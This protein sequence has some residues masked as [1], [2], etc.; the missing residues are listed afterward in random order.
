MTWELYALGA[1]ALLFG[2]AW[3]SAAEMSYSSANRLRISAAEEDG[4]RGAK[5]ARKLLDRFT[6]T[7]AAI[8]IGNNLCNIGSDSL[9]TVLAMTLLGSRYNAGVSVG[10]TAAVTLFVILFCET[11]PKLSAKKNA[12]RWTLSMSAPLR[13]VTAILMPAVWVVRILA[14]WISAPFPKDEQSEEPEEAAAE[15]QSIIETVEDEG[16]IDEDRGEMLLSALDF[17]QIPVMDVMTARVDVQAL[18]TG[19][20]WRETLLRE[21]WEPFSRIPVYEGSIDDIIGILPVN[22]FFRAL[23]ED[24]QTDVRSCLMEPLYVYKTVKLP[25]VLDQFRR[26]QQHLAVV[27]DEYGGTLGIVTLEDVLEQIVGDIWDESDE[28]E[29]KILPRPDGSLEVD[30]SVPLSDFAE[31]LGMEE[32]IQSEDSATAGGWVLERFGTFPQEG[33]GFRFEGAGFTVLKM[34][35]DGRRVEKILVVPPDR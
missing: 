13:L 35:E 19:E 34:D 20:D 15:L 3:C 21:D 11:V 27:T 6:D 9:I 14:K 12:N 24:P 30:G 32:T 29:E 5:R 18:D 17:S 7:L 33:D 23:L 16:V 2:S 28:V 1:A 31:R 4:V 8:L 26:H 22:R 10:I 25:D